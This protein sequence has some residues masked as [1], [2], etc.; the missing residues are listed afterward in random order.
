MAKLNQYIVFIFQLMLFC[1]LLNKSVAQNNVSLIIHPVETDSSSII[2]LNLRKVFPDKTSS[3]QY[4]NKLPALLSMKG[5]AA[6][7]VDSVWED[8]A[9]VSI[10]LFTGDKYQWQAMT[11]SDSDNIFLQ[12]LGYNLN[13][14]H[15]Q[16]FS[17]AILEELY[18]DVLQYFSNQGYPFAAIYLDS[19]LI[20]HQNISAH[21]VIQKGLMYHIDTIIVEGN[22]HISKFFL[23][24][25][26]QLHE[27]DV[28]NELL[29]NNIN[30][31]LALLSYL[32]Q[33]KPWKIEMLNTGAALHLFLEPTK[34]NSI[35]VL[36]GLLPASDQ[37][38]GK[39]LFTGEATVGLRN[40]FGNGETLGFNWQQLQPK[41]PQLNLSFQQP[42]IFHSPVG[43]NAS[44]QL[45][46]Q[47][48]AFI[49]V[50]GQLGLQYQL[51]QQHSG[52]IFFQTTASN[53]LNV[54][55]N[56]IKASG[57]LPDIADVNTY[58]LGLQ[59]SFNNTDYHFNP[60]RGND[61]M[62]SLLVGKKKIK[63]NNSITQIMDPGFNADALYDSL[64][65]N[66]YQW[67]LQGNAAKYFPLG[68]QS[69]FKLGINAGWYQ[70]PDYFQNEL[71]R[72][73]GFKILRGFDEE[74]IYANSYAVGT[75]E[76]RYLIAKNSW[77]YGFTDFGYASYNVNKIKFS[78]SY[79]GFGLG[80]SLETNTGIF[81]ISL[82]EGKRDDGKINFQQSKIHIG[83]ISLF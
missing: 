47:D 81:S 12:S 9:S 45:Y 61:L 17:P 15:K 66:S 75:G 8:S 44:F 13:D 42:Y 16:N 80:L 7:S 53:I 2:A 57:H 35:N 46:K 52:A 28:Y 68:K 3:I 33:S 32:R 56:A 49:N 30:S 24:Q 29:L 36:V 4:V 55:T 50:N 10:L 26:L 67:K 11:V 70:T 43:V 37:N 41:S 76:Y 19:I 14:F 69:T 73:G 27:H 74:S 60:R 40:S 59:Y 82:A 48:S 51:T 34:S 77:F 64:H 5:F 23:Q 1:F 22:A 83:F 79:L 6:A 20:N 38:N 65:L 21:L 58:S 78:H 62:I 39:L 31:K 71:F 72:I 54:D 18:N 63:K 25:Y